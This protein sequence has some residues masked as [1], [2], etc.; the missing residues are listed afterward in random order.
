MQGCGFRVKC[1]DGNQLTGSVAYPHS[2]SVDPL[3]IRSL[4]IQAMPDAA[5]IF[6]ANV[7]R[8]QAR[9]RIIRLIK[10]TAHG[11]FSCPCFQLHKSQSFAD[12][13]VANA[14]AS[15]FSQMSSDI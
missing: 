13:E 5:N 10:S 2:L 11:F 9:Q 14:C 4:Q 7:N 12:G 15:E 1:A 8:R 6:I 3:W